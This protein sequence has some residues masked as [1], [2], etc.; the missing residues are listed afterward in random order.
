[1]RVLV[2]GSTYLR[3]VYLLLGAA[4]VLAFILVDSG[5]VALIGELHLHPIPA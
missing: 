1:M 3:W 5:L 4:L 2:R